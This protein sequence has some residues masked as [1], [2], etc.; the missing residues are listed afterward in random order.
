MSQIEFLQSDESEFLGSKNV[1]RC[2]SCFRDDV[3]VKVAYPPFVFGFLLIVSCGMIL[4]LR[5]S[6]CV[7]CGTMRVL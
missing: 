1:K 4:L 5:P 6:R 2:R 3:H 7:C